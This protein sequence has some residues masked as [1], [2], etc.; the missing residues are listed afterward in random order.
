MTK[1]K[2]KKNPEL[3]II[4]THYKTP[5][6]LLG[7]LNSIEKNLKSVDYEI[8]VSDSEANEGTAFLIKYHHPNVKYL[9]FR[10]NVGYARLVNEGLKNAKG[11]FVLILNADIVIE[12]EKSV[13]KMMEFLDKHKNIGIVG[14][15]LIN[16]DGS[17]QKS[18]FK[19]YSLSAVFARRTCWN[20]TCWGKRA[21][22]KFEIQKAPKKEPLKVDWVMGSAIMTK[23]E[24]INEIG[25][26]DERY[27]MYFGDV[28]W[29]RKFREEGY[30]IYYLPQ[31]AIKHFHLKASDSKKG[32]IDI[33]TNRLTR[34]HIVSY[35]KYLW[36]WRGKA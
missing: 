32:I 1:N 19:E 29:C 20:R 12:N 10:K 9:A 30:D 34:I 15:K 28:D 36:K 25:L 27:F 8:F 7:C 22:E 5:R 11:K 35:I 13:K 4:I 18:Y 33:F 17:I 6:L 21:L 14:P 2:T 24:L 31:T 3:S 16:I 26:M 23:K